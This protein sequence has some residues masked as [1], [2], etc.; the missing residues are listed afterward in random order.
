MSLKDRMLKSKAEPKP[1]PAPES[2]VVLTPKAP[3]EKKAPLKKGKTQV[4][5]AQAVVDK[6]KKKLTSKKAEASNVS[7]LSGGEVLSDV[8]E[9]I[10]TGFPP[11]DKIMGGG[12]AVGRAT[13]LFG[14]E[15]SG[16]SALCHRAIKQCQDMGGMVIYID[17]ENALDSDK[18]EQ[19][20]IDPDR[21]IYCTPDYV[22]QAWDIVWEA[23]DH[24]KQFP[25]EAPTLIIWDSVAAS[26]PKAELQEETAE[27][28]HVG[29]L[30]RAMAKGCRTMY[31]AI[32]KVRAHMIFVNHMT[33]KI[34]GNSRFPEII[35]PGGVEVKYAVSAR[36]QTSIRQRIKG[37]D[38]G[39]S[40]YMIACNTHK[41][42]LFPPH[43]KAN[44]VLDFKYGPSP[45]MTALHLMIAAGAI[46]SVGQGA[47]VG[48]WSKKQFTKDNWMSR[49]E[50]DPEFK[51]A[52]LATFEE[53]V[54]SGKF[55]VT[56]DDASEDD[57]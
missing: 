44:W 38:D 1:E 53:G 7:L 12:W 35:T 57:D 4:P 56:I 32:A 27:N 17:F 42:R 24:M 2:D 30:A 34:G 9:W 37:K 25:P 10:P 14:K 31:R 41:C 11:L 49:L 6:L 8:S 54:K 50:E 43:R 21:L 48:S 13:E 19:I 28:S 23:I 51:A 52:A 16:K 36:V 15:G 20:G 45:E 39:P 47:Y 46:K 22:E 33:F 55:P 18:M 29:L 3:P 5:Y 26:V 40:G